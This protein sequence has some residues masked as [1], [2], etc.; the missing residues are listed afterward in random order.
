MSHIA[1]FMLGETPDKLGR[2]INDLQAYNY[3]WLEHDHKFIQVLFPTDSGHKFNSHALLV[4]QMD[5]DEFAINEKAREAHLRSLDMMLDY[6]GFERMGEKILVR[7]EL[8][9]KRHEWLKPQNHNQLRIT[10]ILRSLVLLGNAP[11]AKCWHDLL[12]EEGTKHQ[13]ISA[14]TFQFWQDALVD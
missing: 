9:P 13:T 1:S 6:Y 12:I 4:T 5:I 14:K 3:F 8:L 11:L 2:F 7:D 10:R